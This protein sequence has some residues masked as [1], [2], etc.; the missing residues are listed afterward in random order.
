[1]LTIIRFVEIQIDEDVQIINGLNDMKLVL[2]VLRIF[3]IKI[4]LY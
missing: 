3:R 1:M 4:K 2:H